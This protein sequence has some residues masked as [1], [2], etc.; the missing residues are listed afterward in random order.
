MNMTIDITYKEKI[1]RLFYG[2]CGLEKIMDLDTNKPMMME[3]FQEGM[4]Y[5]QK[6]ETMFLPMDTCKGIYT[7]ISDLNI[8]VPKY[9]IIPNEL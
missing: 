3:I 1:Y 8:F 5:E 2:E 4:G 7:L 9:L 6:K